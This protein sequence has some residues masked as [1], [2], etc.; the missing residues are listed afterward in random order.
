VFGRNIGQSRIVALT[1]AA[2][3]SIIHRGA[4][5]DQASEML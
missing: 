1:V 4:Y 5:V 3:R 2:V